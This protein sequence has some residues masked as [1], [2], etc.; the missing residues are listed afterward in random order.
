MSVLKHA[1]RLAADDAVRVAREA[2]GLIGHAAPLPSERDQNFLLTCDTGRYVLKIANATESRAFL[3][4]QNAA[5]AHV[6]R[7][8]SVT[9]E[10]VQTLD[11][12]D[13][14][15]IAPGVLV[16]A[17]KWID[18]VP[19][20]RVRA[21]S[22]RLLE[23]FGR[24][25]GRV[26]HALTAFD[27]PAVH[28]DF[29]W[30]LARAFQTTRTWLPLVADD[31]WR[32]F[33]AAEIDGIEQR[34]AA[35]LA[36]L[37]RSVIH[38]DANDHNV[39]TGGGTDLFTRNQDV[40]GL[41]D[42]GDM[43]YSITAADAAVAIAYAVLD[44]PGALA[45][46]GH[47]LRGYHQSHP[48]DAE[49][50][51]ALLDLV[52]LRLCLS[53]C[54]AAHQQ[55]ERP[56]DE[57]LA[58]SQAPIRRTLPA[59]GR[60]PVTFAEA[61][62]REACG[63]DPSPHA[64]RVTGWLAARV[65]DDVKLVGDRHLAATGLRHLNL[66]VA[67]PL[68]SLDTRVQ[69]LAAASAKI[70]AYIAETGASFA[71]GGY[72]EARA[73]Y[74]SAAFEGPM[75]GDERR[76]IHLGVDVFG[77]AGSSVRAPL[78]GV[79]H[80]WAD[81]RGPLDYG[82]V[83][84]LKHLT[85]AGDEFFTLYGHLS[86]ES[87]TDLQEGKPIAAGDAFATIGTHD[88]NGGWVP[89]LH[90]QIITD[91]ME[92]G[93]HFQGVSRPG[94]VHI[95]R[96]FSPDPNLILRL[97]EALVTAAGR[98]PQATLAGRRTRIGRN[99]RLAYREPLKLVRGWMQ[100]LFDETGQR[101]LDAYTNVPHVGHSH[102]AVARAVDAQMR[103]LNTNTRYLHD[104]LH[105]FAE[106]LTATL[107]E[108]LRTCFFV[109]SGSEANEL[110]LRL[111]RAHTRRKDVIVLDAA[112]HGNTTTLIDISPYKFNGPGG[113]GRPSWVH[114][115]PLP[116]VFRGPYKR[117]DVHAAERYASHVG[118]IVHALQRA[119]T[120]PAAFIA[121]TCPSV[122]GQ[123]V[124]PGGYFAG[125]Y[126][127]VR[128][129]GGVCI[130]DEVQTAYG[131]MGDSFYAFEA[132]HVVPDIVV[133]GKPIGNGHPLG[134]VVTTAEIAKSFDNGMEFFS[135]FGGNTVSCAAGLA[136]LDVVRRESLQ[137]HAQRVGQH[138][139]AL[140]RSVAERHAVAADVRGSGLF[141]GVELV[142][143]PVSLTP[144]RAE[145]DYVVNRLRDRR[146]LIGTDGPFHNVLKIRP[147]MPFGVP[148]ADLLAAT[149]DEVLG[150]LQTSA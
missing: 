6:A 23:G 107:P 114:V 81:N 72:L 87:L 13:I 85:A 115:A 149:L 118:Q 3:E 137:E 126:A 36:G 50:C 109:S 128:E 119:G 15:D 111:A 66:G 32:R 113:S 21:A 18:G 101:Y 129:A 138:L 93:C 14:A 69:N 120:R 94:E 61:A 105:E 59:L 55:R 117:A 96:V 78:P 33:L 112:Y 45:I 52:K 71:V 116:D 4:A 79:I 146:I 64:R 65:P 29:Y 49:E 62:L 53:A 144:A 76:T 132:H 54:V 89:H 16:R 95:R 134:A 140:L 12:R 34:Q 104:S 30:D 9:P 20:A 35:R 103:V 125:A 122:G 123:I 150:E 27:H 70:A 90:F 86:R 91:L 19:L 58:V 148:D 106:R 99:V 43:V 26:D 63:M 48:V 75:A 39:L 22:P 124:I 84:L 25:M 68:I 47:F 139:Q 60:I 133:L 121:E 74:S 131:R 17:V 11:G 44:K 141:L 143:D 28:R 147:P 98:S 1:P 80:A 82:P 41:I 73:L 77:P 5:L 56:D 42:F 88:V 46:A 67:S 130:A 38:N 100:Y 10:I 37:R 102:P 7:S 92:L 51:A 108:P 145:A 2:F 8:V 83:I 136:V 40:R 110:A 127:A 31:E 57:Y 24:M 142:S 135:T 97:P